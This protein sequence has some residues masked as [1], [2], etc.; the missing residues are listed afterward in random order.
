MKHCAHPDMC[1]SGS[2][3]WPHH[4]HWQCWPESMFFGSKF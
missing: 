3:D 2:Y 4:N 1:W